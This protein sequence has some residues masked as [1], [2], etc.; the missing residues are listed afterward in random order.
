MPLTSIS[1]NLDDLVSVNLMCRSDT[2][3]EAKAQADKL[4]LGKMKKGYIEGGSK[5]GQRWITVGLLQAAKFEMATK[6]PFSLR[7]FPVRLSFVTS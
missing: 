5:P 7:S 2:P 3:A 6:A 1:K 4:V